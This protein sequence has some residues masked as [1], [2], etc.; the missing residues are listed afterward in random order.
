ML[1]PGQARACAP[2][3]D[4]DAPIAKLSDTGCMDPK[5]PTRLAASV[6]PYEVNSPLWSDSA[7]KSR[8]LSLPAG[9]TIHV[10][11]CVKE[12]SLCTQGPADTGKWVLPRGTVLVKSFMFDDKLVRSGRTRSTR[13]A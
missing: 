7:D 6:I 8:G 10:K 5:N 11:D 13:P 12:S 2:P 1:S 4:K 9:K 3:A